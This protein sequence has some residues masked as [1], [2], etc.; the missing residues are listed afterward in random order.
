LPTDVSAAPGAGRGGRAPRPLAATITALAAPLVFAQLAQTAMGLVD[1]LMVG[2]LGGPPLAALSLATLLFSALAMSLKAVDVA[3]QTF[4]ARRVGQG[5]DDQVGTV[6]ATALTVVV[7]LGGLAALAVQRWPGQI[8]ELVTRD[9]EVDRLGAGYLHWRAVGLVP[10]LVFF[11]LKAMGDGIGWT[12][13]GMVAGLG[14]NL[15]NVGLNWLLIFGHAGLPA[16]GVEG[17]AVAT[18]VSGTVAALALLAVYLRPGPRRRFRLLA[19]GNFHRE[20]V[21]PFLAMAWPPAV[22]TLG[23]VVALTAFYVILGRISTGTLAVGAVVLR[24]ASISFM[25][26]LGM[27][28]A[29][30]TMVGQALGAGDVSGARRA[31]WTGMGLAMVLMGACGLVFLLLAAPLLRLFGLDEALVRLGVP[32]LR[33]VGAAQVVNAVGV[34]LAGGL[35]GAGHTRSVMAVDV[36]AGLGLMPPLAWLFGIA[37]GGDLLGATWALAVWFA[38]YSA[39]MLVLFLRPHWHEVRS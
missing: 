18:S 8:M 34:T 33:L 39:G 17:A 3:C 14:M 15:L 30:Q 32:A 7:V 24:L 11:Q 6:L 22:Q 5:R 31:A 25:P 35:R 27:G 28:A 21:R 9:P 13:V 29:V 20:L 38:L 23:V 37:M 26:G 16:L 2:R 12:R 1:A 19:R 10:L 36:V 4:T